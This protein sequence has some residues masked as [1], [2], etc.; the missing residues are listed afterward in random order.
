MTKSLIRQAAVRFALLRIAGRRRRPFGWC[1]LLA[2]C[3]L[4]SV[5]GLGQDLTSSSQVSVDF[6]AIDPA[7]IIEAEADTLARA[8]HGN[9][10][11]LAFRGNCHLRQGQFHASAD[12]I[13]LWIEQENLAGSQLPGKV[14]CYLDGNATA[15]WP[16]GQQMQDHRWMGRFYSIHPVVARGHEVPRFDIPNL[17][18]AASNGIV[19]ANYTSPARS[20]PNAVVTAGA[21]EAINP[22]APIAPPLLGTS[23]PN[24]LG[25]A[26]LPA[27]VPANLESLPGAVTWQPNQS[28]TAPTRT[29]STLTAPTNPNGG[30]II[31]GFSPA[32]ETVV[33]VPAN[34]IVEQTLGMPQQVVRQ[35]TTINPVQVKTVEIEARSNAVPL[36]AEYHYDEVRDET[37]AQIRNGFRLFVGG[38]KVRQPDGSF[39]EF[40]AVSV[41]ADNAVAWI[42]GK[43]NGLQL[44]STPERPIELYL[45]GNIVFHQDNRV[46]YADR[47]YYNVSSEYGTVLAAEVLTPVQQFQGL[48]RL[49]ADVLQM[50]NRTNMMAYGAAFT[51]SRLGVPRYWMQMDEVELADNRDEVDL[52]VFATS[53]TTSD[54]K[55]RASA[56]NNFVY[57]GGVPVLYWP[58]FSSDL[59]ESSFYLSSIKFANDSI[60][61]FQTYAEFDAYQLMGISGPQGTNLKLSTDYLS[62][63]GPALGVRFDYDRPTLLL[64]IPGVGLTDAWFI[65]DEGL[66]FVG[67]D[68]SGLTPEEDFRGRTLS[69]HRLYPALNWELLLESGWI[70]DR[71]FLE[72]YFEREWEQEKDFTTALRL[73]RYNGNRQFDV[74]GQARVNDFFTETEWLPR[75]D[76]YWLGQDL[77]GQ[78]FTWSA[79]T[80]VGYAH[81]RVATTPLDPA[82]SAKFA[83]LPWETESEG[84]RAVT[85]Q[86]LSYPTEL[87]AWKIVPF[88]S[89]EAG[90][91]NEDVT[92][93]DVSRLT[94]QA[95]IRAALPMWRVYPNIENR[96]FDLRGI[97]H[98]VTF[99]SEFFYAD[100]NTDLSRMPLYDPLDDNAQEHFRRRF[101]FNTFGG[102][103]PPE[104]DERSFALRSGMQRWITASSTEIVDD[105]SQLRFGVNQRWQTKRGLAGRERI[106]DL[107]SLDVDFVVFPRATRDNF[108]EDV[109]AMNYD[110]RYHVGDRLTLL[111]D[112]YFDVFSQ[113]LKTISAGG[114][115]SRPGVG[116]AYLGFLSIEGPISANILNGYLNYRMNE[117]WIFNGGAAFDFG[118]TGSIGQTLGLTRIGE[119]ALIRFGMNV[120]HGRNN[121][122]FGFNIE[123]RF[124]PTSRLGQLGGEL[125]P[126]AGLYGVE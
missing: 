37:I 4:Q 48:L 12:E 14:L 39:V 11:V 96:L 95:G 89:G 67:S 94:G 68:R 41:E 123:P 24:A 113:G 3:L 126:P 82:D 111:S 27:S 34:E 116:D 119:S 44:T 5:P 30:L 124:L 54:T 102:T 47:M 105:A 61:G 86:E 66:D 99:E 18:W 69:R 91:W 26:Q 73:R 23:H 52:S 110:F 106:V 121:V 19:S 16:N 79:H 98:K 38:L 90:F 63:R 107:V 50:R 2:T 51:S 46:I 112:G 65:R 59:R 71:N 125:I 78:R 75:A 97:A 53:D 76:H 104:F 42:R 32:A 114:Q 58:T 8:H 85:R 29:G 83:T 108:G 15:S 60:F 55:M 80:S 120:D 57:V 117:K 35:P 25:Q 20:L 22:G 31:D 49:K 100:S 9:Y 45:D 92:Q 84:A 88:L 7:F 122:S 103:L 77:F 17:N 36:E 64:G 21:Q 70:S 118:E 6:P 87:G 13:T 10:Q 115:M 93:N 72:Q 74:Y 1:C 62:D 56:T 40:G 81:Q 28:A 109:G 43:L 101:I 33:P